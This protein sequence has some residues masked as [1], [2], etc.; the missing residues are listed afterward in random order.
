M[1]RRGTNTI[2]M[3]RCDSPLIV[4]Q[5]METRPSS[6]YAGTGGS[7]RDGRKNSQ[8]R[9]KYEWLRFPAGRRRRQ[10]ET[11]DAV[12][13]ADSSFPGSFV[14]FSLIEEL[15]PVKY[16][17]NFNVAADIQ[18]LGEA[19]PLITLEGFSICCYRRQ[20]VFAAF[21]QRSRLSREPR[22]HVCHRQDAATTAIRGTMWSRAD[23]I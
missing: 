15:K 20:S 22:T 11:G 8:K 16:G 19:G 6:E 4:G 5:Q 21:V 14:C 17:P 1:S 10:K 3:K 18:N 13:G 2:L 9:R 23:N 7:L 12:S